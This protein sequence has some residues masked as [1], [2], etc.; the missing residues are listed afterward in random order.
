[1]KILVT[2]AV[3]IVLLVIN[4]I[5]ITDICKTY[6]PAKGQRRETCF[7]IQEDR[8][9]SLWFLGGVDLAIICV[10]LIYHQ[11][12]DWAI[13]IGVISLAIMTLNKGS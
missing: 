3:V 8:N 6:D 5:V 9:R 11:C 12:D 10:L 2:V 1:M 7:S 4:I 13:L